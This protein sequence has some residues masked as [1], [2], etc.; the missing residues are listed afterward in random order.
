MSKHVVWKIKLLKWA[1]LELVWI[2]KFGQQWS[3]T[4]TAVRGTAGADWA[5][6]RLHGRRCPLGGRGQHDRGH[7]IKGLH[8]QPSRII[9]LIKSKLAFWKLVLKLV[10]AGLIRLWIALTDFSNNSKGLI[11]SIHVYLTNYN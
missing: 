8:A 4:N 3:S 1:T 10:R 6:G 2:S 5:R 7:G 11:F 9:I